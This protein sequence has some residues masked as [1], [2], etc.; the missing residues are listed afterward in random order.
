VRHL[1]G[2]R[3]CA[4]AQLQRQRWARAPVPM[5]CGAAQSA[6][7]L[8]PAAQQACSLRTQ[9]P[10]GCRAVRRRDARRRRRRR[11]RGGGGAAPAPPRVFGCCGAQARAPTMCIWVSTASG[12]ARSAAAA[13]RV[14]WP[15]AAPRRQAR[16]RLPAAG[17]PAARARRAPHLERSGAQPDGG[18]SLPVRTRAPPSVLCGVCLANFTIPISFPCVPPPARS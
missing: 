5:A 4:R 14:T 7:P 8:A 12:A 15:R 1:P 18:Q 6:R 10:R 11:R 16:R 2:R 13:W 9:C 17:R 3:H